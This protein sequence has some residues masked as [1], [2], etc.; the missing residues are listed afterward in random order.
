[1]WPDASTFTFVPRP[2]QW[3]ACQFAHFTVLKRGSNTLNWQQRLTFPRAP[4]QPTGNSRA[5]ENYRQQCIRTSPHVARTVA[6]SLVSTERGRPEVNR[7]TYSRDGAHWILACILPLKRQFASQVPSETPMFES[8]EPAARLT[9]RFDRLRVALRLCNRGF[10]RS[11]R[12]QWAHQSNLVHSG[13]RIAAKQMG[14]QHW[15]NS[16][17]LAS[18]RTNQAEQSRNRKSTHLAGGSVSKF[19]LWLKN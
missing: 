11:R 6:L 13:T 10:I 5:L 19:P 15:E 18:T 4:A 12:E 16:K 2:F 7:A 17:N 8:V 3:F 1:M 9:S 14:S